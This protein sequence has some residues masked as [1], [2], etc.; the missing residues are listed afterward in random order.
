MPWAHERAQTKV[1]RQHAVLMLQGM[2]AYLSGVPG[3]GVVFNPK[4]MI[5]KVPRL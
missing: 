1:P 5:L 4:P 3:L 2:A